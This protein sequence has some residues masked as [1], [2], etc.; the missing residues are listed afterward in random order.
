MPLLRTKLRPPVARRGVVPRPRLAERIAGPGTPP[1]TV[2]SAPAGFGKTTS[3]AEGLGDHPATAWLSLDPRDDDPQAFWTYVV[4]ALETVRPGVGAGA[5]ALLGSGRAGSD[6][7]VATLLNDLDAVPGDVVLVLDDYHVITSPAIHEALA[8]MVE[9]LPGHVRL[10]IAA[11]A[12]PP[13]PLAG[14]R[15]RGALAE[16]RAADLRFAADE[17]AAYLN[18]AMGLDLAPGDVAALE[19]RTEGWIAALQLAA[20]SMRDR[21]DAARFVAGFAGDDRFVL[22]YLVDEVLE[23]QPPEIRDFLLRTSILGRLT[24]P[25]CDAVT[26]GGGGAA[27]LA[28]LERANLF[29]VPLDDRRAWYRYHHLF[30][31]VLHARLLHERPAEVPDLHRRAS[32][33]AEGEGDLPEAIRHAM[34]GGDAERA[35]GLVERAAP[36]MQRTRQE[37]TL[38]R[39]LEALPEELLPSRP[40]LTMALIGA[41]MR[42]GDLE[43]IASGLDELERRLD[44]PDPD[45]VVVDEEGLRLIPAQ[46]AIFRSALAL[47]AGDPAATLAHAGRALALVEPGDHLPRGSAAALAGLAHWSV[48]DLAPARERYAEAIG[49]L[50]RAG[51][52][53]DA[54]GCTL[55]LSDIEVARG[56]LGAAIGTLQG[57]L[58]RADPHGPIRGTADMHVALADVLLARGDL[59]GAA[60][61]LGASDALGEQAGLPQ[62]PYRSRVAL[63]RLRELQGDPAAASALLEEAGRRFAGDFSPV[64]RPVPA[65]AAR[66]RLRMGDEA[67]AMRWARDRGLEPDDP[68]AY[69]AEYEHVTL[70]R[71][72]LRRGDAAAGPLIGR[73]LAAAREGGREG[74]VVK[75]LV[76]R[77]VAERERDDD[78]AALASLEE[79]LALAAPEGHVRVFLDEG[80]PVA[81]LLRAAARRGPAAGEARRVLAAAG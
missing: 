43:G 59:D 32:A 16:V 19:A 4:A 75:L 77:A 53:S 58:A 20:L 44:V 3:V 42:A 39:W 17:A 21:D 38:R 72:L 49:H 80:A 47:V 57:G 9:R 81:D 60:R 66:L 35:A 54:L 10:V 55:A 76:L 34:A 27:A 41:R 64:V 40:V 8:F 22:D 33:W 51:N 70:A 61:H 23:R 28:D 48:G 25:L 52:V 62:H 7:V 2:V 37:A 24:G 68:P 73:L 69:L 56:R 26:G 11:R 65:V 63:A 31:D 14:L 50:A 45:R 78:R 6:A 5:R 12:D 79:A 18:G 29:L 71:I 67:G 30:A 15:A 36:A 74:S 13:L 1:L 46:A